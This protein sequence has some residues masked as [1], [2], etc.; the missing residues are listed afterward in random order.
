MAKRSL[1][2]E[3]PSYIACLVIHMHIQ[4]RLAENLS[5]VG[6]SERNCCLIRGRACDSEHSAS[7]GRKFNKC[8]EEQ[9]VYLN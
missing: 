1:L 7:K 8:S 2:S 4:F 9:T 6:P 3:R 5:C